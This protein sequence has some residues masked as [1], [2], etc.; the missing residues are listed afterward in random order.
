MKSA[1]IILDFNKS[2]KNT[3]VYGSNDPQVA[4]PSLYVRKDALP[5]TPP[6]TL[7][8]TLEYTE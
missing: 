3:H 7:K 1:T 5:S 2:T 6:A 8:L 4:V